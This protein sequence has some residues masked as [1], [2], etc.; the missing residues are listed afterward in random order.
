MSNARSQGRSLIIVA[1]A[2]AL[3]IVAS[4]ADHRGAFRDC[5]L[6]RR[7][8]ASLQDR[9]DAA[10]SGDPAT[11]ERACPPNIHH[12]L[13][14]GSLLGQRRFDCDGTINAK[15]ETAVMKPAFRAPLK[16]RRCL[17]PGRWI[18]EIGEKGRI[19]TAILL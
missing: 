1:H 9:P 10:N 3:P 5:R 4:K 11:S 18:Y 19:Q 6:A 14:L 15:S 12:A 16:F 7:L 2:R 8:V 17:I 13:G